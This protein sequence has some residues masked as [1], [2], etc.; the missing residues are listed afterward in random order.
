M[1]VKDVA[2]SRIGNYPRYF[3][4]LTSFMAS[5]CHAVSIDRMIYYQD[6]GSL[7]EG[8][9]RWL[10]S[11]SGEIALLFLI[12]GGVVYISSA[13]NPARAMQAKKIVTWTLAGLLLVLMSYSIIRT[14]EF[15]FVSS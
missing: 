12:Y 10:L 7:V 9:L 11:I 14:I 2:S 5:E 15:I 8:I 4:I 1:E 3:L 6:F 13:G